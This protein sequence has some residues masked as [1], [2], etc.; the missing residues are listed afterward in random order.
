M[1]DAIRRGH[2]KGPVAVESKLGWLISGPMETDMVANICISSLHS[3]SEL[4]ITNARDL[5]EQVQKCWD[6]ETVGNAWD[7]E[8]VG[9]TEG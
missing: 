1:N 5:N 7:I 3:R 4:S 2:G 6:I 9:Y 8:T